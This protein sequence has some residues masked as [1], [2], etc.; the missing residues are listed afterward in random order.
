MNLKTSKTLT[1][2]Y[3]SKKMKQ[4]PAWICWDCG[5]KLGKWYATSAYTGPKNHSATMHY[6]T[7]DVCGKHDVPCTEPR[8]YGHL[9]DGWELLINIK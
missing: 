6:D 9:I 2:Q 7:C 5:L 8:D 4:Y 3:F 1:K